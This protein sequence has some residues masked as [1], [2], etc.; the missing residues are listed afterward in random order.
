[1]SCAS[2]LDRGVAGIARVAYLVRTVSSNAAVEYVPLMEG[3]RRQ[4]WR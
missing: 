4:D 1:M 2:N 3:I